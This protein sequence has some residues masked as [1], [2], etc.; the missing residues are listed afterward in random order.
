MTTLAG[1]RVPSLPE[2]WQAL[3]KIDAHM[4]V[5]GAPVHKSFAGGRTN[6]DAIEAADRLGIDQM[7]CSVP[8]AGGRLAPMEEVR[9]CNDAT[10]RA[11]RAYPDRILG[12]CFLIPG[13]FR[14]SQ[15]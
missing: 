7:L 15:D 5:D 11:M 12:Y 1:N 14:E 9:A 2:K 3:R 8:I 10:I 6:A 13:Y 4:H